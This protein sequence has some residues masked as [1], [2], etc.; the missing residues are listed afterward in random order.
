MKSLIYFLLCLFLSG[1][2][3]EKGFPFPNVLNSPFLAVFFSKLE[4]FST[5]QPN[6]KHI[7][8]HCKRLHSISETHKIDRQFKFEIEHQEI[9]PRPFF[10][11]SNKILCVDRFAAFLITLSFPFSQAKEF[12]V[13]SATIHLQILLSNMCAIFQL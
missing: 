12:Q 2:R 9:N 4:T 5:S 8:I 11:N 6:I 3:L 7:S 10:T 13:F 1:L